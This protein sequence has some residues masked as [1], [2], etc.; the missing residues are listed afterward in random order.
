VRIGYYPSAFVDPN[1]T[2]DVTSAEMDS[3]QYFED[4]GATMVPLTAGPTAPSS[5]AY[6]TGT[7]DENYEG[8]YK[9]IQENPDNPYTTPAQIIGSQLKLPFT[10]ELNGYTG[11]GLPT[12]EQLANWF[13]ERADYKTS[14]AN[15]MSAPPVAAGVTAGPINAIVY[16]GLLSDISLNDGGSASFG[17]IDTPSGSSGDPTMIFPAG[18]D[19]EGDPVDIQLLGVAYSDPKL[20]GYAYA[21]EQVATPAG[22]G[23]DTLGGTNTGGEPVLPNTAPPLT[24]VPNS[25][26]TTVSEPPPPIPSTNSSA[27]GA[28]TTNTV[29]TPVPVPVKVA[30]AS[31]HYTVKLVKVT[32]K[33]ARKTKFDIKLTCDAPGAKNC[34]TDLVLQSGAII[35][36]S[37]KK[38]VFNNRK[39]TIPITLDKTGVKLL[40][41]GKL[42]TAMLSAQIGDGYGLHLTKET[43]TFK[44]PVVKK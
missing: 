26:P 3:F 12:P 43:V 30:V 29:T 20:L 14:I 31:P 10:R 28:T 40:T 24:Y 15:Y 37:Q 39:V 11:A 4:A 6:P 33:L 7:G 13:Q 9:W 36:F 19:S 41:S 21:Y 17:R 8:W 5:S 16:P 35:L 25:S 1:G 18:V 2:T 42:R 27:F 32:S 44:A 34:T 23:Y 38:V 22:H